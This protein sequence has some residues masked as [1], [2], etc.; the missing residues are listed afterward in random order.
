[1]KFSDTHVRISGRCPWEEAPDNFLNDVYTPKRFFDK[2]GEALYATKGKANNKLGLELVAAGVPVELIKQVMEVVDKNKYYYDVSA[3]N[4]PTKCKSTEVIARNEKQKKKQRNYYNPYVIKTIPYKETLI[5]R[6]L[7]DIFGEEFLT[8]KFKGTVDGFGIGSFSTYSSGNNTRNFIGN[9]WPAGTSTLPLYTYF[10]KFDDEKKKA[11]L[12]NKTLSTLLLERFY[13]DHVPKDL[14]DNCISKKT[15][16]K[17]QTELYFEELYSLSQMEEVIEP[18]ELD[19]DV[20]RMT[21]YNTLSEVGFVCCKIDTLEMWALLEAATT[22]LENLGLTIYHR[23]T[24]SLR[25]NSDAKRGYKRL[26]QKIN[27]AYAEYGKLICKGF[28]P[29]VARDTVL[30]QLK[31][32]VSDWKN[33]DSFW[34]VRKVKNWQG[35]EKQEEAETKTTKTTKTKTKLATMEDINKILSKK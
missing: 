3:V 4:N 34:H 15:F 28:T 13:N 31:F 9:G 18:L 2:I 33:T 16:I 25:G 21:R 8:Q 27:N 20:Y 24:G 11:I 1:M 35:Q 6:K 29:E 22:S 12:A 32:W 17:T 19:I 10:S 7:R 14:A 26:L 30:E 5:G 23:G